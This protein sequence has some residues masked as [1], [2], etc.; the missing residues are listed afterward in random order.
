MN[1]T[2]EN[3]IYI[4]IYIYIDDYLN[5]IHEIN[6]NLLIR[7]NQDKTINH[8]GL[9]LIEFCQTT[10]MIIVNGRFGMDGDVG[11][12]TCQRYNGKSTI[13]YVLLS[14]PLIRRPACAGK[15]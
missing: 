11:H 10:D 3:D 12:Y 2:H 13:V 5:C 14:A 7:N 9:K 8:Q 6:Y 15:Q 1:D 4:Y